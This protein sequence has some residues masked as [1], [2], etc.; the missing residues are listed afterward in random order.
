[1]AQSAA[2][3][4]TKLKSLESAKKVYELILSREPGPIPK[5]WNKN[6]GVVCY[7]L[8]TTNPVRQDADKE[9][10]LDSFYKYYTSGADDPQM[11][12]IEDLLR[13]ENRI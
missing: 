6:L 5:F 13:T 11:K 10:F 7:N 2:K 3:T 9:C 8:Y 4:S 1:M 12:Q